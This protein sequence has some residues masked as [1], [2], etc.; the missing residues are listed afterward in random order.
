[1]AEDNRWMF[2]IVGNPE[3]AGTERPVPADPAPVAGSLIRKLRTEFPNATVRVRVE[4]SCGEFFV[5]CSDN[6]SVYSRAEPELE[7]A[8]RRVMK[9][10]AKEAAA[11]TR[12]ATG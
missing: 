6:G 7:Q 10:Q 1:M 12:L 8:V 9:G 4:P 2:V 11:G 5:L 3:L